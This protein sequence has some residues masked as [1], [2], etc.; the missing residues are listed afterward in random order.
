MGWYHPIKRSQYR[1]TQSR[2]E[3][4]PPKEYNGASFI[5]GLGGEKRRDV[6]AEQRG[7]ATATTRASEATDGVAG[8]RRQTGECT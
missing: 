5:D 3:Q 4:D 7:D 1:A 8:A 2:T 6:R